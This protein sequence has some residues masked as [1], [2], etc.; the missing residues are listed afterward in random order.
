MYV[1][2]PV[3]SHDLMKSAIGMNVLTYYFVAE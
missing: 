1:N 3:L 2:D